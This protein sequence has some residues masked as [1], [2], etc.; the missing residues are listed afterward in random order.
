MNSTNNKTYSN[1]QKTVLKYMPDRKGL[2]VVDLVSVQ[3]KLVLNSKVNLK[4]RGMDFN[5]K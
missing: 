5:L 1:F 4:L 2:S 3:A